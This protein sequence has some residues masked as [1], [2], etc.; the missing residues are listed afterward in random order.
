MLPQTGNHRVKLGRE[1]V[2]ELTADRDAMQLHHDRD[3]EVLRN[4][5][6]DPGDVDRT[7]HVL[8]AELDN[9]SRPA[10]RDGVRAFLSFHKT[11]ASMKVAP[12]TTCLPSTMRA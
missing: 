7:L 3:A 11:G 4:G 2:L 9:S 10:G 1:E 8:G 6:V 12:S 5:D